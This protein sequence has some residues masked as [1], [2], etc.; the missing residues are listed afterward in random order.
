MQVAPNEDEKAQK[1]YF[2]YIQITAVNSE[3][4]LPS[5]IRASQLL[6]LLVWIKRA[7]FHPKHFSRLLCFF[8]STEYVTS[9]HLDI[10][11]NF[12]GTSY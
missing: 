2:E 6:D 7:L 11:A 3:V 4:N 8:A 5:T 12:S 10:E 1:E 9:V